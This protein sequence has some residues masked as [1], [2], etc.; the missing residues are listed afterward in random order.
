MSYG[1]RLLVNTLTFIGLTVLFPQYVQ[2]SSFLYAILASIIL[3][4]VNVLIRPILIILSLP[5]TLLSFGLF[6]FVINAL[7]L[8]LTSHILGSEAFGFRSF[9][10]A[11]AVSVLMAAINWIIT[12]HNKKNYPT[13]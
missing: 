7:M 6:S 5:F 10:S 12:D 2:V 11:I 1:Q 9:V 3:S 8:E 13:E 4:V